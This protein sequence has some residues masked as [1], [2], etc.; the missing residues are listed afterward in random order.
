M[1]LLEA[2]S[3]DF[4]MAFLRGF[5]LN[6]VHQCWRWRSACRWPS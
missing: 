3:P 5:S 4:L 2:V 6:L 1:M